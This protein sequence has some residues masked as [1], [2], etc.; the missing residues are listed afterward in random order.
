MTSKQASIESEFNATNTA[1]ETLYG[2]DLSGKTAIV[3]GGYSGLGLETTR[4]LAI[5][6]AT[7]I[8]PARS[9]AKARAA[10]Q[11]IEGVEHA[12]IDLLDPASIDVFARSFI[13]SGRRLDML[14]NS[15]GIMASPLMR[16]A[17]GYESQFSANHLGHFHL[18]GQL[19]PAL[20]SAN[21]ARVVSVSSRAHRFAQIDFEDPQFDRRPYDKWLSYA[22]S[23]TANALFAVALDKRGESYG[24]RAFSVHPGSIITEL[25]RFLSD[26]ELNAFGVSRHEPARLPAGKSVEEGGD[27]RTVTQGAATAVWCATSAELKG[28]GGVY[29]ENINIANMASGDDPSQPGVRDW[30]VDPDTAERLWEMSARLTGANIA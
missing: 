22:Q 17:R 11:G 1:A 14:V 7:V 6:G 12:M 5:A 21:G 28:A 27:F 16:D 3:T 30:A 23:K 26:E 15:A 24:V 4:A 9:V 2:Q 19:W 10:L 18:T 25:S 8:V 13:D 29:C 20:R